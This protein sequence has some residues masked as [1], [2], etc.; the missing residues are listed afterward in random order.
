M[1][2]T[3]PKVG[4]IVRYAGGGAAPFVATIV[5]IHD[6]GTADLDVLVGDAVVREADVPYA[7]EIEDGCWTWRSV[8]ERG[9]QPAGV[10]NG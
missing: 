2:D 7:D 8:D 5:R 6:K 4:S 1:V 10:A 3:A 9:G